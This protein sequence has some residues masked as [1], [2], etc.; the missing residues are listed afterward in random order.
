MISITFILKFT[1]KTEIAQIPTGPKIDNLEEE[2]M[3]INESDKSS[4]IVFSYDIWCCDETHALFEEYNNKVLK[5]LDDYEDKYNTLFVNTKTLDTQ[6]KYYLEDIS[7]EYLMF[8]FPS[9]LIRDSDGDLIYLEEEMDF[10]E[11]FLRNKLDGIYN[12]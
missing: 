10:D 12:D 1:V 7:I 6:S 8:Q 3:K 2:Y 11:D 5:I 9:I 4:I